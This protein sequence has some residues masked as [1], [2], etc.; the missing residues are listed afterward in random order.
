[1]QGLVSFRFMLPL[2]TAR[3][4]LYRGNFPFCKKRNWPEG[5]IRNYCNKFNS[6]LFRMLGRIGFF[7]F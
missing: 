4:E 6:L 2:V 3:M 7:P 1:M 5:V